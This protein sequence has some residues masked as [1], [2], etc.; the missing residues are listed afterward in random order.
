MKPIN[1]TGDCYAEYIENP[2]KKI[3]NLK[4]VIVFLLLFNWRAESYWE[5]GQ[6]FLICPEFEVKSK[7]GKIFKKHNPIA[8]WT[9]TDNCATLKWDTRIFC[10]DS[11]NWSL[12]L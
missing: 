12:F 10:Q 3:L 6:S 7:I 9:T 5:W 2:N 8:W 1:V 4:F 11:W